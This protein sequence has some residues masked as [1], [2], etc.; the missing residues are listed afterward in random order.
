MG[1]RLR[2]QPYLQACQNFVAEVLSPSQPVELRQAHRE[3]LS[4][5]MDLTV[6]A[7]MLAEERQPDLFHLWQQQYELMVRDYRKVCLAEFPLE[8]FSEEAH[9]MRCE[10]RSVLPEERFGRELAT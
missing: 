9:R 7:Q 6:V 1:A 4:N 10:D 3:V 8:E 5:P 2:G